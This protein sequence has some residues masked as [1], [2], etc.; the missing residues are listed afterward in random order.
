MTIE[1]RMS[2]LLGESKAVPSK[3]YASVAEMMRGY[4]PEQRKVLEEYSKA[5]SA[6]IEHLREAE[7]QLQELE[8]LKQRSLAVIRSGRTIVSTL[9]G[10][11][12]ATDPEFDAAADIASEFT[13]LDPL[14]YLDG[15]GRA[16]DIKKAVQAASEESVDLLD[17]TWGAIKAATELGR[18]A[19]QFDELAKKQGK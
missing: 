10:Y 14:S 11:Q 18:A 5:A 12:Y 4:Y 3:D 1:A 13:T 7:R 8:S 16:Y 2:A 19:G 17:A 9:E 15:S 6:V